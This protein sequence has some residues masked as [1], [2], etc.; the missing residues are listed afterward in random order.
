[1]KCLLSVRYSVA[2]RVVDMISIVIF[3]VISVDDV[4]DDDDLK[5]MFKSINVTIQFYNNLIILKLLVFRLTYRLVSVFIF[6]K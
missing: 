3:V 4:Y 5:N 6:R 1:M 2:V